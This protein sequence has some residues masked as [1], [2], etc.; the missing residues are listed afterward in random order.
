ML[1]FTQ[2]TKMLNIL[3][4]FL[5]YHGHRYLRLDGTTKVEQR[6]VRSSAGWLGK[7][8]NGYYCRTPKNSNIRKIAVIVLKYDQ[9]GSTIE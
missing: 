3:E 5:S 4:S 2:M 7:S 9:C 8:C 6:Q 1:I